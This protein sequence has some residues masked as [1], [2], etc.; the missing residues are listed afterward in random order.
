LVR[1]V[2]VSKACHWPVQ[3]MV[4]VTLSL[5]GPLNTCSC[6]GTLPVAEAARRVLNGYSWKLPIHAIP[7]GPFGGKSP[8]PGH[9][10][11][12]LPSKWMPTHPHWPC[13]SPYHPTSTYKHT[14]MLS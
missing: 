14:E 8:H 5:I 10:E 6:A 1:G 7:S 2:E 3:E 13:I 4:Q 9:P 11:C 12:I